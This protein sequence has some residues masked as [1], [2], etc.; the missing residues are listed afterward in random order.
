M[1]LI[2]N[3]CP[4]YGKLIILN[5]W[6]LIQMS[7]DGRKSAMPYHF[8]QYRRAPCLDYNVRE[9][10]IM[11]LP[12]TAERVELFVKIS[13]TAKGLDGLFSRSVKM[14]NIEPRK[15]LPLVCR[16]TWTLEQV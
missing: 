7:T 6:K 10:G 13:D 11:I 12:N 14:T 5:V 1:H 2:P 4:S 15:Y 16:T 8:T 3:C 9:S